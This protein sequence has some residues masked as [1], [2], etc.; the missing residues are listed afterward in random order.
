MNTVTQTE[1]RAIDT[2]ATLEV[3]DPTKNLFH[4]IDGGTRLGLLPTLQSEPSGCR[5]HRVP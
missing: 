3:A 1:A 4:M 2:A 5:R